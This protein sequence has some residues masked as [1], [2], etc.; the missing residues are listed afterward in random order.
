MFIAPIATTSFLVADQKD[1]VES[2]KKLLKKIKGKL[3][4]KELN[5]DTTFSIK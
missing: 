4:D 5:I 1:T 3:I 2:G